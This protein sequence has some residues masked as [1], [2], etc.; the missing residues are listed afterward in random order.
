MGKALGGVSDPGGETADG[1]SPVEDTVQEVEIHLGGGGKGG[2]VILEDGGVYQAAAEHGR[3]VHCY[4]I[5]VRPV[6][7]LKR[8]QGA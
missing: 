4:A 7:G 8:D 5:T 6:W 2:G 3:T 1:T